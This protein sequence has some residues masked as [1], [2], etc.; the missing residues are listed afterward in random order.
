MSGEEGDAPLSFVSTLRGLPDE[1]A[2]ERLDVVLMS[3]PTEHTVELRP[4]IMTSV[5]AYPECVI[6]R[7]ITSSFIAILELDSRGV[8]LVS[9]CG[10][11]V[12]GPIGDG[13]PIFQVVAN[14]KR[15]HAFLVFFTLSCTDNVCMANTYVDLLQAVRSFMHE[16]HKIFGD[17]ARLVHRCFKCDARDLPPGPKF[18]ICTGCRVAA[19]C[20]EIHQREDWDEVHK[21]ECA[22]YKERMLKK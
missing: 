8:A 16:E 20:S 3:H 11:E 21:H 22:L 18:S 13:T 2:L 12:D 9:T 14:T 4:E 19:Y 5:L 17:N 6:D 1:N 10:H 7:V 15:P